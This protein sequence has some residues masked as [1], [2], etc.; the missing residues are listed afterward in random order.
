MPFQTPL[1][2]SLSCLF[3]LALTA[4]CAVQ[5][6]QIKVINSCGTTV[7]PGLFTGGDAKPIQDTGWELKPRQATEFKVPD[8]WTAGRVWARTGC[9]V[10]D[11]KFQCL[12]GSCGQGQG[13][14][15]KWHVKSA[16]SR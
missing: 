3:A 1:S 13:G 16:M 11:G 14:D 4:G 10:Q 15:Q 5:A 7:W 9:V 2:A 12:T 6:R 8:D